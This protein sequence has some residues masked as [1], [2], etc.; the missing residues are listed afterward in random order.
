LSTKQAPPYDQ[1]KY[2]ANVSV[3]AAKRKSVPPSYYDSTID[4]D[5]C[6]SSDTEQALILIGAETKRKAV[7]YMKS[8]ADAKTSAAAVDYNDLLRIFSDKQVENS[9]NISSDLS[10][11]TGKFQDFRG[12]VLQ[13]AD[14]DATMLSGMTQPLHAMVSSLGRLGKKESREVF[15]KTFNTVS[16][17]VF[18]KLDGDALKRE[19]RSWIRV[20]VSYP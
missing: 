19:L 2:T 10:T 16:A 20:F 11:V 4:M 6:I 18:S 5:R 17:T 14:A 15:H 13:S 8:F 3:L 9:N 7:D 12:S 1:D